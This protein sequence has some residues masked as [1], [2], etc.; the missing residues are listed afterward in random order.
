MFE[1]SCIKVKVSSRLLLSAVNCFIWEVQSRDRMKLFNRLSWDCF[2]FLVSPLFLITL[3]TQLQVFSKLD[4]I[5]WLY[6]EKYPRNFLNSLTWVHKVLKAEHQVWL[7]S[8]RVNAVLLWS[9][10]SSKLKNCDLSHTSG[11]LHDVKQAE[12]ILFPQI[13]IHLS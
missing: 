1:H 10:Q 9:Q 8:D 6:S 11:F 12:Q 5:I 3:I 2:L 13:Q 7:I 4:I